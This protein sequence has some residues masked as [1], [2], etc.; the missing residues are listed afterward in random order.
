MSQTLIEALVG[1]FAASIIAFAGYFSWEYWEKFPL[2]GAYET[3]G[4]ILCLIIC[5]MI[6]F[7]LLSIVE[8]AITYKHY[9]PIIIFVFLSLV[10]LGGLVWN[11]FTAVP[12]SKDTSTKT[13]EPGHSGS[14]AQNDEVETQ[15][16]PTFKPITEQPAGSE[17]TKQQ[18]QTE[19]NAVDLYSEDTDQIMFENDCVSYSQKLLDRTSIISPREHHIQG[20]VDMFGVTIHF[21]GKPSFPMVEPLEYKADAIDVMDRHHNAGA[22]SDVSVREAVN[23]A[24]IKV[25]ENLRRGG[26]NKS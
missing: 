25:C 15:Q 2:V 13:S 19:S 10:F 22:R 14:T 12:Q 17:N 26:L 5:V 1:A 3:A 6:L 9:L 24:L 21:S 16:S 8:S 23:K 20:Q 4:L 11:H 18:E 7:N